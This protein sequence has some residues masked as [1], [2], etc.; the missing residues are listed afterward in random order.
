MHIES[1]VR[2]TSI[3]I[4]IFLILFISKIALADIY[5]V[6]TNIKNDRGD[7]SEAKPKKYIQSGITLMS[8]KGGDTLILKDGTYSHK[9]DDMSWFVSGL[10][11]NYN[12]IKSENDG[13][14]IV[15]TD[16][17]IK[18]TKYVQIE[19]LKFISQSQKSIQ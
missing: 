16:L 13:A 4:A 3:M 5:Y 2:Y 14:V 8:E 7:G 11:S 9:N 12:I 19:G 18:N 1:I 10:P 17:N 15:T 6:D